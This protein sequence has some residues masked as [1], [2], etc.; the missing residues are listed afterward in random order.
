MQYASAK[1]NLG[2]RVQDIIMKMWMKTIVYLYGLF[3]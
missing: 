2:L 1:V 3:L